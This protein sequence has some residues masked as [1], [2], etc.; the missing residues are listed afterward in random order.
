MPRLFKGVTCR[1]IA[2]TFVI[3]TAVVALAKWLG[4]DN[5]FLDLLVTGQV[6]GFSAM[7]AVSAAGN[8]N[9]RRITIEVSRSY[10]HLFRQM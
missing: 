8:M 4:V 3:N 2:I 6:I 9:P 10:A 7:L 5:P 1:R